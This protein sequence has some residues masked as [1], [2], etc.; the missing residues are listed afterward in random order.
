[1]GYFVPDAFSREDQM[2]ETKFRRIIREEV[3][4]AFD[5]QKL[6]EDMKDMALQRVQDGPAM[7]RTFGETTPHTD[8]K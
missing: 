7:E 5:L 4:R 1:M 6:F 8:G 2:T 3:E